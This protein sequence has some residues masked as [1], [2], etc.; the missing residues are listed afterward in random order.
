MKCTVTQ[1]ELETVVNRIERGDI[2]LQPFFQRGEVWTTKKKQKLI[3]SILRGWKIPP[4]HLVKKEGSIRMDVLDGQQRLASIRDFCENKFSIDANIEPTVD[5]IKNVA[6]YKYNELNEKYKSEISRYSITLIYI[7]DYKPNEAAELFDRLNQ[8]MKLTSSEQRNAYMG[9]ARDQ[10]KSVV[11]KF[12][13]KGANIET[14][15]FSNSRLRYD[16]LISKLCYMISINN[17]EYKIYSTDITNIYRNPDGFNDRVVSRCESIVDRF[18]TSVN[19][20]NAKSHMNRLKFTQATVFSWFLFIHRNYDIED[21]KL[22]EFITVFQFY[23]YVFKDYDES[24]RK[25]CIETFGYSREIIDVLQVLYNVYLINASVG[26]TN[27]DAILYRD[28]IINMI[29]VIHFHLDTN[30]LYKYLKHLKQGTV[31]TILNNIIKEERW[32][33]LGYE[34]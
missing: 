4:I 15:G 13:Y 8:P 7:E 1:V 25:E 29:Y 26:N 6:G 16:D 24:K 27:V 20:M 12:E 34:N 33:K 23:C 14:I 21:E 31:Y 30:C 2:N 28:I 3:D 18:I 22:I 32:G 19:E 17:L 11:E 5:F 10:V 9:K